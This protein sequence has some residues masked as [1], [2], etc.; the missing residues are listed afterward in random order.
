MYAIIATGGKQYKVTEGEAI[1]VELLGL[2]EGDKVTFEQVMMI[3]N[4]GV[5][6][7][8]SPFIDAATVTGT[9]KANGKNKKVVIFKY[10]AKKHYSKKQGHR[11]PFTEVVIDKIIG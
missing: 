7:V 2:E 4:E 8:G 3:S 1:R 5:A 9:V 6:K 11:Q 10:K